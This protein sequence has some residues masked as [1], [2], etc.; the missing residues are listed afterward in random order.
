MEETQRTYI[1]AAGRDWALP[2]YDP[3]V[4]LLGGDVA[5]R[6]LVE[7]AALRPHQRVLD[8]GCGTGTLVTLIKRLHPDV[9]VVGLDPDLR[10]LARA[11][12]KAERASARIQF[13][14]GFADELPYP[15]ASFDR[16]FS[17][18]MFHHLGRDE[19][20]SMLREVRRILRPGGFLCLL[21]FGGP[22][23]GA[24]GFLA[25]LLHSNHQFR[26]NSEDR[27]LGFM[28]RAGFTSPK[29]VSQGTMFFGRAR[30]NYYQASVPTR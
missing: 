22:E 7:Q 8:V 30:I 15:E 23:S 3:L 12:R 25:R 5:R 20:E 18:L 29:K 11:R 2:L 4:K 21:D 14:Q 28:S 9:E 6:A 24:G 26:D 1:P 17:S 16:V 10:A 27:I 13:D 19:K